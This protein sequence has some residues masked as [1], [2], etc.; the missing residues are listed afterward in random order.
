VAAA[1]LTIVVLGATAS[2]GALTAT[3]PFH[4]VFDGKHNAALL[5]EGLFTTSSSFCPSGSAADVSIDSATDTSLRK[6]SCGSA[7]DFSAEVAPLPAEHGGIGSWQIVAGS[8]SLANLRGKGTWTS[9]RL[10]GRPDDPAT[11]TFRSTWDGVADFDVSPPTIGLS[12]SRVQKL[13]RPKGTY[14][15]RILLSLSDAGGELVSFRLQVVDTRKPIRV[16]AYKVGQTTTGTAKST[17][18]VKPAKQTRILQLKID[19]NDAV[20]NE[21]TSVKTIRLR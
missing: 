16:L 2:H 7:G 17:V 9:T 18:Q 1:V 14:R 20:G 21:A 11:I 13:K 10:T 8:G 6:F 5:H 3:A 4:L 15:L 19:A 12:S